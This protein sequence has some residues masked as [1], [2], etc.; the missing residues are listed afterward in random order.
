C[1]GSRTSF[2]DSWRWSFVESSSSDGIRD[3]CLEGSRSLAGSAAA[4]ESASENAS[5]NP[6]RERCFRAKLCC[7]APQAART[8]PYQEN[9]PCPA[10]THTSYRETAACISQRW[11]WSL[12]WLC[13]AASRKGTGTYRLTEHRL[14]PQMSKTAS[15]RIRGRL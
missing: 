2:I 6:P 1:G 15:K 4:L 11:R 12:P 10:R 3:Q 7:H 8:V 5:I 14:S 9:T 13:P